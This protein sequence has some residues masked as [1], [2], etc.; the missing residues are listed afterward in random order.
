M[1]AIIT[2]CLPVIAF[3]GIFLG[4]PES[5]TWLVS[6]NKIE[7][8]EK[9]LSRIRLIGI[10]SPALKEEVEQLVANKIKARG[11]STDGLPLRQK[12]A[13]QMKYF[14]KPMC[15]KPLLIMITFFFFQQAS[16]TFVIVFYA[17]DFV[18]EAGVS[19][20]PYFAAILIGLSRV[21]AVM[22]L[23]MVCRRYGRRPPTIVSGSLMTIFM[24][25]LSAY[26]FSIHLNVIGNS[27]IEKLNW[28]PLVLVILYFF[29]STFGF[30]TMPFAMIAEIFPTRVRGMAG[31]LT[32]CM[33]YI[34]NFIFIKT[35]TQ[36]INTMGKHGVFCFYGAM[37]LVG[38]IFIGLLLPETKGK[39]LQEIENLFSNKQRNTRR[40]EKTSLTEEEA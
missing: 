30:L 31:G 1:T 4:M 11:T 37:A 9:A 33:C 15:W 34:F 18:K 36:M 22:C 23:G 40:P 19:I 5:P 20:D 13:K 38:T 12:L 21:I 6:H 32:S 14:M 10:T 24:V 17:V 3:I 29:T 16:G 39:T 8:A 25:T 26:L 27:T 2:T 35:Y 7:S 28:L